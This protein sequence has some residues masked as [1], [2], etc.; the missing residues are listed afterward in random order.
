MIRSMTGFG[1]GQGTVGE[2]TLVVEIRSVNAKYCDVRPRLPREL[3]S[4][5]PA[6]V[7][8]IKGRLSRGS[9]EVTVRRSR[10]AGPSLIPA[11]DEALAERVV[12]ELRDLRDRLQL[13]GDVSLADLLQVEGILR[14]EEAGIAVE[15]AERALGE[16]TDRALDALAQMRER[17]GEALQLDL[18]GRLGTLQRLHD[19]LIEEAPKGVRQR[20][21]RLEARIQELSQDVE[22]EPQR[23]VQEAAILAERSDISEELT[24][25][26][27]HLDHFSRLMREDEPVGRRLDFL[28]QEMNRE[29]NTIASKASWLPSATVVVDL[30]AEIEKIREQ[31]QNIE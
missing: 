4:L 26:Q 2:E 22:V 7:R 5:E 6:L 23:L 18:E 1:E 10:G 15:E 9:V 25:L 20:Q 12:H 30:K 24:R 29:A 3:A 19:T 21:Q 14:L 16:A 13:G 28:V 17:E 27:A 11:I 31:I 8:Q